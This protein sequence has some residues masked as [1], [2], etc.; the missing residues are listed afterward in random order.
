[1]ATKTIAEQ[2]VEFDVLAKIQ[3]YMKKNFPN[4]RAI[5]DRKM[6]S[7]SDYELYGFHGI[8]ILVRDTGE[9]VRYYPLIKS[10]I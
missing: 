6:T 8:E 2:D 10:L 5:Q 7:E 1:M 3:Q 4:R 9:Y